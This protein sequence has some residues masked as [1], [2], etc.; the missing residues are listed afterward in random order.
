MPGQD[1]DLPEVP[2]ILQELGAERV[3]EGVQGERVE[4]R[5]LGVPLE[6]RI[7]LA[8]AQPLSP[9]REKHVLVI[10]QSVRCPGAE[11]SPEGPGGLVGHRDDPVH[12]PLPQDPEGEVLEVEIADRQ[13]QGLGGPEAGLVAE[14]EG[15]VP[16]AHRI[17]PFLDSVEEPVYLGPGPRPGEGLGELHPFNGVT[18]VLREVVLPDEEATEGAE[19]R[20][21]PGHGL[22]RRPPRRPW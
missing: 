1:L 14:E 3:A 21:A 2:A 7:G 16:F 22:G 10:I 11:I 13:G 12:L 4:T 9:S 15:Q 20:E 5:L 17:P 19:G 8:V 6:A 18:R